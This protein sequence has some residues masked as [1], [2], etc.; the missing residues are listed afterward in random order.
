MAVC[1]SCRYFDNDPLML[2][3]VFKGINIL[4]SVH[5]STRGDAG[6]CSLHNRFLLPSYQCPDY[7]DRQGP[8][9]D[10]KAV[11]R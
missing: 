7:V 3:R 2:E 5:G 1:G 4:S 9:P 11:S 6:I 8:V 10:K